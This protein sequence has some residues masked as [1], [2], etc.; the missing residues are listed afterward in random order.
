MGNYYLYKHTSPSG[1]VYIGITN[2]KPERRWRTDGRGYRQNEKFT[3]AIKKYGW[4]NFSHE[5][6]AEGLELEEAQR[7]EKELIQKY[8]SYRNGYNK[9]LGGDYGGYTEDVK[10]KISASVSDLWKDETYRQHMS[11]VHKGQSRTGWHHSEESKKKMSKVVRER[12]K[13]EAYRKRLSE[14]AKKRSD[15]GTMSERAK[16]AWSDPEIRERLSKVAV[17][18]RYRAKRVLCVE[19]GVIYPSTKDAAQAVGVARETIGQVCR[20]KREMTHGCHWRF[21]DE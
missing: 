4:D 8:E 6:I 2:Q 3:N 19:T 11:E 20:G 15:S 16:K 5:I 13:D 14:S 21:A 7:K 17:G 12:C 9:S 10:E 18:N 1:K